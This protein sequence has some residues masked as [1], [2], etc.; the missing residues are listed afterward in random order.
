VPR[1]LAVKQHCERRDGVGPDDA[2]LVVLL[3]DGR[4]QDAS[5]ASWP[6]IPQLDVNGE[7]QQELAR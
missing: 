6:T 7:L 3:L 2:A 5:H 1:G 4:P